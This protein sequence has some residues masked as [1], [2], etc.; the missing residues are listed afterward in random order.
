[1][2]SNSSPRKKTIRPQNKSCPAG[3]TN[4]KKLKPRQ[5]TNRTPR[6]VVITSPSRN[7]DIISDMT[8][9]HKGFDTIHL[10]IKA[11]LTP[12]F[13][14]YLESEQSRAREDNAPVLGSYGGVDFHLKHHGGSGY[15]F[16]LDG[17]PDGASWAFK[18]PHSK[19]R[20]GI[21]IIIGSR[22]LA[23]YGLGL[24]KSHVE[25]TLA[26][27]GIRFKA[28]DVSIARVDFCVDVFSPNFTLQSDNFVMHSRANW[29]EYVTDQ[30]KAVNGKS[31]RT[32]SLTIGKMPGRQVIVYDKR[33]EVIAR[34]KTY[35]WAIWND[36]LRRAGL[37]LLH[38]DTLRREKQSGSVTPI[39]S[40]IDGTDP[41]VSY[42]DAT[43]P[44]LSRIWRVEFRAGKDYLKDTW[45][46][47]TWGQ[48]FDLFGDLVRHTGE[49]VRYTAPNGDPNRSRWPN[50]LLWETVVAE[51][52]DDLTEMRSGADPN[53]MKE[54]HKETHISMIARQAFG[55]NITLTALNGVEIDD[56]P[57]FFDTTL[58]DFK[59]T[60]QAEPEDTV[61]KL[62]SAKDRYVFLDDA[63]SVD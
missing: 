55:L 21:R 16:L 52:N 23:L 35:W 34:T 58:E 15:Q 59:D 33:A 8:I 4:H 22:F 62:Q 46:I 53:P 61:K 63:R 2:Q 36:T 13:E 26:A 7:T 50:H 30:D 57:S 42:I 1:M 38:Y 43:D 14:A 31:S 28:E 18:R 56:L 40:Y 5:P 10:S 24:A 17:G 12:E 51:M 3:G 37:P 47:R 41:Y 27:W 45:G 60:A 29:R 44:N 11:S 25:D 19:D 39:V 20:W 49:V 9:L 48:L 6:G 32:T 54:V